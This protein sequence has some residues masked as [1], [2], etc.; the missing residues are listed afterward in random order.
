MG[1]DGMNSRHEKMEKDFKK[2]ILISYFEP[3]KKGIPS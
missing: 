2:Y 1:M 3:Q